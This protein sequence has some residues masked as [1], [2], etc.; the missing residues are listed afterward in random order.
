M[1]NFYFQLS[2][3]LCCLFA[4]TSLGTASSFVM[5]VDAPVKEKN[6]VETLA[7]K[8][9]KEVGGRNDRPKKEDIPVNPSKSKRKNVAMTLPAVSAVKQDEVKELAMDLPLLANKAVQLLPTNLSTQKALGPD[10]FAFTTTTDKDSVSVGEEFELTVNVNW[11]DYGVNTGVRFLP[12]WYKYV[13]KVVMPKGFLQTGGDYTDYCT[14]PV[15]ANNPQA[16]FTIKGKFEYAPEVAMFTI[17]RGFEGAGDLSGFVWKGERKV[18]LK[19]INNYFV[20]LSTSHNEK[21]VSQNDNC[22]SCKC[23]INGTSKSLISASPVSTMSSRISS[24]TICSPDN[25]WCIE[26]YEVKTNATCT[27]FIL[28]GNLKNNTSNPI[29]IYAIRYHTC[30]Y[31]TDNNTNID[32]LDANI[33]T[34][35]IYFEISVPVSELNTCSNKH[36]DLL[37]ANISDDTGCALIS[38]IPSLKLASYTS[39]SNNVCP[40]VN[41][42]LTAQGCT[43]YVWDG[44][45]ETGASLTTTI[46]QSSTFKVKCGDDNIACWP[47]VSH[48][49]SILS[50]P[51]ANI[52]G[53]LLPEISATGCPTGGTITWDDGINNHQN[54]R[55]IDANDTKT[56]K[57][58]CT[59]DGCTS[60]LSN[61]VK[62]V[63]SSTPNGISVPSNT[64]CKSSIDLT[65]S[66]CDETNKSRWYTQTGGAY[67]S[68]YTDIDQNVSYFSLPV[69][70]NGNVK[71]YCLKSDGTTSA[72]YFE[73]SINATA[74]Q[75][76]PKPTITLSP[77]PVNKDANVTITVG[78]CMDNTNPAWSSDNITFTAI[79]LGYTTTSFAASVTIYARCQYTSSVPGGSTICPSETVSKPLTITQ[80]PTC[81]SST[82][83]LELVTTNTNC[84]SST[85]QIVATGSGGI[86][87][88]YYKLT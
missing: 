72:T 30:G 62:I 34:V 8:D 21:I 71:V 81:A 33:S 17:L 65:V 85:G 70:Y 2:L 27:N 25:H 43:S 37:L 35:S 32:I 46:S 88:R 66:G 83:A 23:R 6:K 73:K 47:Q 79:P 61:G 14:K 39:V 69:S 60:G 77:N 29:Y 57:A 1:K 15:D 31:C 41:F 87:T 18:K 36:F 28:S 86:G 51:V 58:T 67:N 50:P 10:P 68:T 78:G 5:G 63:R 22:V 53:T 52:S 7:P 20:K 82:L 40:N 3:F 80:P 56:Y 55:S 13:L 74:I 12:E 24:Q 59:L 76:I 48:T 26:N 38:G 49:V 9:K 45:S 11:V 19:G 16:T 44:Y 84:G 42:T 64:F 4:G 54:P 75:T